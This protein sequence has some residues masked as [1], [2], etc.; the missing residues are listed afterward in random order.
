MFPPAP[1][2]PST[3]T[4]VFLYFL[5]DGN[6]T[7]YPRRT[8]DSGDLGA[9]V[10]LLFEGPTGRETATATTELPRLTEAPRVATAAD[11]VLSVGLPGETTP[12]SRQAMLQLTCT[13][14]RAAPSALTAVPRADAEADGGTARD[15]AMPGGLRVLG[16]G[17]MMKQSDHACF[18]VL[19][20]QR[21]PET[22]PPRE[23]SG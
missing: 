4:T 12:L 1:A 20:P 17:W 10:R 23:P 22:L 19:H 2:P 14:S 5:R 18:A 6:L 7:P 15:S 21:Q 8:G 11:G 13:V 9:V 16:D 3:P